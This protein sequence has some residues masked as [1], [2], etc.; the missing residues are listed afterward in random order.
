MAPS[1]LTEPPITSAPSFF[2]TGFD[3]P[4]S[5]DSSRLVAPDTITP[6]VGTRSPGFT[7]TLSP[8]LSASIVTSS[9][10]PSA[11][12]RWASDGNRRTSASSAPDAPITE[13]ISIQ[14]PRSIT[15]ISVAS[16]Q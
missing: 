1:P 7:R 12:S 9:V 5:I 2:S 16:S 10:A 11:F 6:S 4:V 15:S 3:S 13:R 14:W 8:V